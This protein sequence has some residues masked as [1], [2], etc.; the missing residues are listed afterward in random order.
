MSWQQTV[1]IAD[2]GLYTAKR[3]GRDAW[4][5][6]HGTEST[7]IE[8]GPEQL[9]A[10]VAKTMESGGLRLSS[11]IPLPSL[12]FASPAQACNEL[13]SPCASHEDANVL[14][15]SHLDGLNP[16]ERRT[17]GRATHS[18]TVPLEVIK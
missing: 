6:L 7:V 18:L 3:S 16:C 10:S 2:H 17:V 1:E 9:I 12:Q 4:V 11:S 13:P 15:N 5:G 14:P 8:G